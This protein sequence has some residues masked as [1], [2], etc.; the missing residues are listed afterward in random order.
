MSQQ[1]Y[2]FEKWFEKCEAR[3]RGWNVHVLTS[4]SLSLSRCWRVQC[5]PSTQVSP[6]AQKTALRSML[7]TIMSSKD[8]QAV[9]LSSICFKAK[10]K[11]IDIFCDILNIHTRRKFLEIVKVKM[12]IDSNLRIFPPFHK[13]LNK[14][15]NSFNKQEICFSVEVLKFNLKEET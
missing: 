3:G 10:D 2:V 4:F 1:M 9:H 7:Q 11:K 14:I 5:G 12:V 15:F 8:R 6:G 13:L